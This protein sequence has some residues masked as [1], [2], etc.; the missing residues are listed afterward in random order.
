MQAKQ[1]WHRFATDDED[2][3]VARNRREEFLDHDALHCHIQLSRRCCPSFSPSSA[4][5]EDPHATHTVQRFQN[6][7]TVFRVEFLDFCGI[8]W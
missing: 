3:L 7:V 1:K 4:N 2:A 8:P 6:D 5:P